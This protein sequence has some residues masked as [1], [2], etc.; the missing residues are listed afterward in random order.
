MRVSKN[1]VICGVSAPIARQLMRA[2]IDNRPTAVACEVLDVDRESAEQQM[3]VFEA[4]GY[5][6]YS[7]RVHDADDEWWVTT[8]KGNALR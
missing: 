5:I 3:M 4:A 7:K 6:G 1:D 8:I 2:F